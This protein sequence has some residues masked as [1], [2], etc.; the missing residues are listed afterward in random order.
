MANGT[1]WTVTGQNAD[2]TS[3][4]TAGEVVTGKRIFFVTGLG[5]RGSVLIPDDQYNPQFVASV[6]D[7]EATVMDSVSGLNSGMLT[8]GM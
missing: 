8:T 7:A 6:I 2:Q 5:N 3:L 1:S 4:T